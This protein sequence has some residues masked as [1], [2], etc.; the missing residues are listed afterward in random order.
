MLNGQDLFALSHRSSTTP[1]AIFRLIYTLPLRLQVAVL[2]EYAVYA[3]SNKPCSFF[4][5][6][7]GIHKLIGFNLTLYLHAQI[8]SLYPAG[9]KATA[10]FA[11]LLF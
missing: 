10:V 4:G 1:E 9:P 3:V 2:I 11:R 8:S 6:L 5:L 7:E